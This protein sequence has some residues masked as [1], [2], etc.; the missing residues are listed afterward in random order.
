M[1]TKRKGYVTNLL[2]RMPKINKIF[3]Y[4]EIATER[5]IDE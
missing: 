2:F 4:I 5:I 3:Q 1:G